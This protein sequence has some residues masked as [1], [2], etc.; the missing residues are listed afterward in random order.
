MGLVGGREHQ[1]GPGAQAVWAQ[2]VCEGGPGVGRSKSVCLERS[3]FCWWLGRLVSSVNHFFIRVG[4]FS[5]LV[6]KSW[7]PLM[8]VSASSPGGG[9]QPPAC[10]CRVEAVGGTDK[11]AQGPP[12]GEGPALDP[13]GVEHLARGSGKK[14]SLVSE[15][16]RAS[17][18]C[19]ETA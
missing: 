2:L 13:P 15:A 18:T 19:H 14:S 12:P 17:R 7:E 1:V 8:P 3:L 4:C 5:H 16:P 6:L 10:L 9:Q 11:E